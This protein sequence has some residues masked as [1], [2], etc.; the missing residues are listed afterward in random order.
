MSNPELLK[1]LDRISIDGSTAEALH[2]DFAFADPMPSDDLNHAVRRKYGVDLSGSYAGIITGHPFGKASGQLSLSEKH[3]ASDRQNGLSFTVLKS[4]VGVTEDGEVGIDEWRRSAPK[5]VTER[6]VA[7]DGREGWTVTWK[8]RGWD[9]SYQAYVELYEKSLRGNPGY[10]V[11]PSLMVDVNDRARATEQVA[12][13]AGKLVE[14]HNTV[15]PGWDFL[16]EIDISPTLTLLTDKDN[17]KSFVDFVTTSV[18]AFRDGLP[19]SGKFIVKLPNAG[20]G[21]E[22][23]LEMVKASLESAGDKLAGTIIGNRLFDRSTTFEGQTGIAY[24][25]WDLSNANLAT[26]DIMIPKDMRI[27]LVGTGNICSGR[28]MAEY[29]LRGC[30][31]GQIHTFFQLPPDAYRAPTGEGG[32][33]WRALRQLVFDTSDGLISVMLKLEKAGFLRRTEDHVLRFRSLPGIYQDVKGAG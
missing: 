15:S 19:G 29:G 16:I 3:V 23:Q 2:G 1:I 17:R 26:L 22:Y 32:R 5:M 6:R 14:I 13:C 33:I 30:T 11:I 20:Y 24:G 7:G 25:G 18:A 27:P 10:V 28:M 8:G 4:A 12:Y 21:A 9:R 31:S